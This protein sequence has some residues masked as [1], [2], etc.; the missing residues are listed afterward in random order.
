MVPTGRGFAPEKGYFY[1][2]ISQIDD[3]NDPDMP[4]WDMIEFS[5]LLDSYNIALEQWNQIGRTIAEN[6]HK[7][8]GYVVLHGTDTMAYTVSALSFM[9]EALPSRAFVVSE[10]ESSQ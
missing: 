5:H 3:M 8:D 1:D 7:Y 6:Y 2:A 4:E 9:L 10:T